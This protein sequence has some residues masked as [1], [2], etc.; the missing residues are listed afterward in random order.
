MATAAACATLDEI[1]AGALDKVSAHGKRL[2]QGITN[3]LKEQ[4]LPGFVQGPETMP[5]VVITEAEAVYDYRDVAASDHA[6][7]EQIIWKLL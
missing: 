5:A 2:V 7:Y 3:V 6:I 1:E 4:G